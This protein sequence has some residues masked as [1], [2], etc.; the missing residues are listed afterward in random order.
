VVIIPL[1]PK[2]PAASTSRPPNG[3]VT[4]LSTGGAQSQTSSQ[5]Q[6]AVSTVS[7]APPVANATSHSRLF[8][9]G[10][11]IELPKRRSTVISVPYAKGKRVC[12][13]VP[14][15]Y[16]NPISYHIEECVRTRKTDDNNS[17]ETQEPRYKHLTP[18]QW[19]RYTTI[20][21]W[22][23]VPNI[24]TSTSCCLHRLHCASHR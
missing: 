6:A 15:K 7:T 20:Y 8:K 11:D 19:Q 21:W 9:R 18:A 16:S 17:I 23:S 5:A 3:N 24:F 4:Q 13:V 10:E 22:G 1:K 2:N 12:F 14:L